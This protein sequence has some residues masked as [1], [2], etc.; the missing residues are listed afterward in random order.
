MSTSASGLI[1]TV[2]LPL[3][4]SLAILR[5]M[6]DTDKI[7]LIKKWLGTG[8]INIFGRPFSGKDSQGRRLAEIFGGN[9]VGGGE[10]LRG[11]EIPEHVKQHMRDGK[12]IPSDDYVNIVLPFLSQQNLANKPLILSSVG[13]WHGEEDGVIQAVKAAGHPLK[14]VVYLDISNDESHK[15]WLARE[16][17]NDRQNR[18]DDT[19]EILNVRFTEFDNK[20]LPVLDYYQQ[21]GMLLTTDGKGA[22]D[23]ITNNIINS[24]LDVAGN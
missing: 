15:R 1:A 2:S 9:L 16:I 20:T 17:N 7:D 23:E 24:L 19:E 13:R 10:I 5:L 8:S 22:R 11:S 4:V 14:A 12:L 18:H 21:L 3:I 6:N